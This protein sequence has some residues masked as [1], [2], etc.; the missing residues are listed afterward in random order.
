MI[1]KKIGGTLYIHKSALDVLNIHMM[2]AIGSATFCLEEPFKFEIIKINMKAGIVSFIDS[3]DWDESR[4]P[5]V[6][7][8]IS[9]NINTGKCTRRKGGSQ[10]YH[11]K[12]LFVKP[13]Y[14]GFDINEAKEWSDYWE[15]HPAVARIKSREKH[16]RS[17]IGSK[18]YWEDYVLQ[19]IAD[20][21]REMS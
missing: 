9:V 18:E 7:D 13:D 21:E 4:N 15:N 12:Y 6:G 2:N 10:V 11:K 8:S 1:G 19:A 20:Y 3:P 5:T 16:F 14:E 17:M